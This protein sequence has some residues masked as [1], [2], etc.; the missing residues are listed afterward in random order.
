MVIALHLVFCGFQNTH[1]MKQVLLSV[2][3]IAAAISGYSQDLKLPA[4]SPTAKISQDFSTSSIEIAYSRPSMRGR[5]IFGDLVAF[6][7]VWRTG[8]NSAT[9]VKFGEDVTVGGQEVKAGEYALYTI[10]GEGSWEVILNKGTGNWGAAGYDKAADVARFRV[11]ARGTERT[12]QTFT[13]E[14]SNITLSSCKIDLSW[15]NTL[16]SIPVKSNN[17]ERLNTAIDKAINN[18]SIPYFQAAN[19]Y[20]E[21]H[22]QTEKAYE[23]VTKAAEQN[24][25][26]FYIFYLKARI[27]QKLGKNREAIEA[28][29]KSIELAK[30]SAF[31]N[32]YKRNNRKII[33]ALR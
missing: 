6:G 33:N 12:V 26:A 7:E 24:P 23:Y 16:I 25:K 30:G 15:E 17:E 3:F 22:Q 14:I 18:P 27:A 4:L 10:P 13:I 20:F 11:K 31:E 1:N 8:A 28:A 29:E 32:D 19:Y 2:L 21:T 5:R 9:K